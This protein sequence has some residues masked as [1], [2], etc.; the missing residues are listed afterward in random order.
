MTSFPARAVL[1][2]TAILGVFAGGCSR[3]P[4]VVKRRYLENGNKYFDRAKYKEARIMYRNA[5]Q[6][7]Q[8]FGEAHYRLALTAL[9][10]NEAANA[11]QAL[12]RA[13]ELLPEGADRNDARVKLADIYLVYTEAVRRQNEII[14][15]IERTYE[16]LL[17]ADPNSYDGRRIKGRMLLASAR[18][19]AQKGYG[20]RAQRELREAIAE[21][22]AAHAARPDEPE[23]AIYLAR[24]VAADNHPDESEAIYR[25]L[26]AKKPDVVQA[27]LE[28]YSLMTVQQKTGDAEQV[29]RLAVQNNPK[30]YPLL[31]RLAEHFYRSKRRDEV[32]RV[33]QDLKSHAGEYKQAYEAAG[34]FYF[35]LGDGAEAIRQYEEGIEKDPDGK[36]RYQ[37]MIIEV[38]M[39]QGKREEARKINEEIL[40][41]DPRDSD[42]LALNGSLMLEKGDVTNAINEL[43]T[44]VTRAPGNFVA[45]FNLGRALMARGELETA[46]Q[47]LNEAIRLKPNY[48]PARIALGQIH[49]SRREFD[50]A[51]KLAEETINFDPNNVVVRL[52]RTAAN[53]GLNNNKEARAEL[54]QILRV[55]P[56]NQDALF[57][58]GLLNVME[59]RYR[60]AEE[61]YRKCYDLNP[62]NA[63]GLMGQIEVV[64]LQEQPDRAM[65]VL[66][67]E[68]DKY[69]TRFELRT[70]HA[71]VAVRAGK[72]DE[73]IQEYQWVLERIDKK[74]PAAGDIYI[75][76]AE[77]KRRKGDLEGAVE[78]M[79]K[80]REILPQNSI[81]LNTLALTLDLLGRKE[82][83]KGIYEE[84]LRLE[85]ENPIVLNNLAYLIASEG[86]DL[87]RALTYAQRARQKLPQVIEVADTL[88]WIYLKKNL[89]DQAIE[90]FEECLRKAP[91]HPTYRYHLGQALFQKGDVAR[92]R[93][94]LQT[95]LNN[96]PSAE[97][98][99]DIRE[100]L[101]RIG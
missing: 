66:Q 67:Q 9:K 4:E 24:S 83:A 11:A 12:R 100:L 52:I 42:A 56:N 63:R 18:D 88:G 35:R 41:E 7:D 5:L 43:R 13:I 50:P 23:A 22:R 70:S 91:A 53:M 47:H 29:L 74:S 51:L 10:L 82:E 46:R 97:E 79:Q 38:L 61:A 96:K 94:E 98:E 64:M 55:N 101:A 30:E 1:I 80:A 37:K 69:P 33:I 28:L 40:K 62:A 65:R 8:R 21:F 77:T 81:V 17:K 3:D 32:V 16:D 14:E 95:A 59:K 25:A 72:L 85:S 90:M 49:I 76:I 2:L 58:L 92:A 87:D 20:E 78:T 99:K 73:A 39:A 84:T 57:Q 45:Q 75:R 44:V 48:S 71:N 6:K 68:I 60:E 89:A 15:E 54:D 19:A 34:A 31:I 27:Y 26:I 36:L 86:G 93:R